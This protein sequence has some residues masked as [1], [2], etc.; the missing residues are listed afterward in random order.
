MKSFL[1]LGM[2]LIL[3]SCGQL[4]V[5]QTKPPIESNMYT[6]EMEA[7]NKRGYGLLGCAYREN[8]DLS[9]K[10]LTI[11]INHKGEY[12]IRS[13]RCGI[14]ID[15][16]YSNQAEIKISFAELLGN[17][18]NQTECLYDVK[19]FVDGFDKGFKGIFRLFNLEE[20]EPAKIVFREAEFMGT[21]SY[22]LRT[23]LNPATPFIFPVTESGTFILEGCDKNMEFPYSESPSLLISELLPE[24]EI[25]TCKFTGALIPDDSLK[26]VKI[27]SIM[28]SRF[29][30]EAIPLQL[31]AIR[32]YRKGRIEIEVEGS[33]A[34][35]QAGKERKVFNC[36]SFKSCSP[37][38][39]RKIKIKYE[40]NVTYWIRYY[41]KI[42]RAMIVAYRN[43]EFVWKPDMILY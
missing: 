20:F 42:G 4:P 2:M 18:Y 28:V 30:R 26:P 7:C 5:D 31:P 19:I 11:P 33:V 14:N 3:A 40:E 38:K 8:E 41:T 43:G 22:Q 6:V 16:R 27:F 34:V 23:G 12:I 24:A 17:R 13:N 10:Y 36:S 35:I 39:I 32:H 29:D 21:A 37:N 1:I 15:R 25:K 9:N